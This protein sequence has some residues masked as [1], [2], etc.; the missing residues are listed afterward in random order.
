MP[1]RFQ[2]NNDSPVA[3]ATAPFAIVPDDVTPLPN[4]PK[5]IYVGGGGTITLRGVGGSEDVTY[6]NLPDASYVAVRALYVRATGTTATHL[7][8][9][10]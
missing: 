7:I 10:A 2:N 6:R 8:A 1:D 9:E 3:P 5:G 4:V